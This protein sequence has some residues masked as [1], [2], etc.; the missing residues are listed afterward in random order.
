MASL[1]RVVYTSKSHGD[2]AVSVQATSPA[3]AW[4]AVQTAFP[5]SNVAGKAVQLQTITEV[6]QNSDILVGS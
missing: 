4:A 3:N 5:A 1:Y 6:G 2:K